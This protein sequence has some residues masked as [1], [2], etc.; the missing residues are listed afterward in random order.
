MVLAHQTCTVHIRHLYLVFQSYLSWNLDAAKPE[1]RSQWKAAEINYIQSRRNADGNRR[2]KSCRARSTQC[3]TLHGGPRA[4]HYLYYRLLNLLLA[5]KI[6]HLSCC[7]EERIM[8]KIISQRSPRMK[9]WCVRGSTQT[10]G[11]TSSER[12]QSES[13][14]FRNY[15]GR[16]C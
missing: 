5:T 1:A 8:V 11:L 13:G 16:G 12:E 2:H 14:E 4:R 7:F 10:I 6:S 9:L 3:Y 15:F